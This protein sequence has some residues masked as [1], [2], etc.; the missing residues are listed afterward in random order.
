[1]L[2]ISFDANFQHYN[3]PEHHIL[4]DG[5]VSWFMVFNEMPYFQANNNI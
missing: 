3:N 2:T 5:L 4:F 1:M